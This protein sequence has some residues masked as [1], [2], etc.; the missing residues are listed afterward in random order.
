MTPEVFLPATAFR[1]SALVVDGDDFSREETVGFLSRTVSRVHSASNGADAWLLYQEHAPDIV[2]MDIVLPKLDGYK[3]I[4]LIRELDREA[5]IFVLYDG[6]TPSELLRVLELNINAFLYKPVDPDKLHNHVKRAA[7]SLF[8]KRQLLEARYS[9]E[10]LL[11]VYPSFAALLEDGKVTFLN[12]RLLDYLGFSG[13]EEFLAQKV[14]LDQFITEINGDP[15]AGNDG[16]W[17]ELLVRD[18]LDRDHVMHIT[19]PRHPDKKSQTFMVA[20]NQFPVPGRY[21]FTFAD[22]SEMEEERVS[23]QTQASVDPLTGAM[24]RRAFMDRLGREQM[25]LLRG[26]EPFCLVMFD[27]DHFKTVNDEYGHDAG[28][29]VLRELTNLVLQGV[30]EGDCLG[31]WGGE[32][33]MLLEPR[34]GLE[35]AR[36]VAERLR[37]SIE[38]F[39]FDL[40]DRTIT[41]SFGVVQHR[42]GEAMEALIKRVDT[43][44]YRAK[45]SGR[46]RVVVG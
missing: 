7:R 33:F 27:I 38:T 1:L 9:L 43:A 42:P 34:A 45:E 8:L 15:Y 31:R 12:R 11:N 20:F 30:R 41:S 2:L 23:F 25:R 5:I 3:L 29:S 32:E 19:N 40:V 44:L 24:N 6:Y 4:G 46:N 35:V 14:Q 28:D 26:G 18:P 36:G 16:A 13:F 39:E 10:Y 37:F 22:V 21:L 17:A